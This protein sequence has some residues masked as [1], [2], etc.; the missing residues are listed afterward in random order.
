MAD[1]FNRQTSY[2][3]IPNANEYM[4]VQKVVSIHSEDRNII[5]YP[6]SSLFEIELPEDYLNVS[7]V[8]LGSYTFPANYN[9]F[10]IAQGN[11]GLAF[12][13]DKI[14]NPADYGYYN[15]IQDIIFN[16]LS[17][18]QDGEYVTVLTEGFYDP[19]QIA[20]E[21][22][23][24]MNATITDSILS[25]LNETGQTD[26]YNLFLVSAGYDQFI[27]VYNEVTQTL[28]FGNKS[29][30]FTIKNNSVLYAFK[31][32]IGNIGQCFTP[33]TLPDFSNWGLPAYLGFTRC[34]AE[35]GTNTL[36]GFYPRF[37]YGD[38]EPGDN[39]YWLKPD[40]LYK[41]KQVYWLEPPA[42]INLMGNS[43]FYMEI[44][45]LNNID[46]TN[47]YEL[48]NFTSTTNITNGRVN[49]A[50]AKIAVST[51]PISQWYDSNTEAIKI[52]NP[53]AERIR[54][55]KIRLR[56]H[57][58]KLVTFGK[59]PWSFNLIFNTLQPQQLR[60]FMAYNPI[61]NSIGGTSSA[62]VKR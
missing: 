4:I 29:S 11:L 56:Y 25:Y 55:I 59:F 6:S 1:N 15:E 12:T 8:K 17:H 48:T 27:V 35:S 57:D 28:W 22:T 44:E 46:E 43:Y 47:P 53:P 52:F 31:E 34:A 26:K 20:T 37:Y 38:V 13:M 36:P 32:E 39:G 19:F 16:S 10:S 9:T 62:I 51:T 60:T 14:Y 30:S 5:K 61:A 3:L 33:S 41:N 18:H 54:R 45:G 2:P 24:K 21:L 49:S 42:K 40:P 58:G 23:N 7:T 50:F